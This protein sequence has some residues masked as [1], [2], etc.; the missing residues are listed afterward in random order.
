M[1]RPVVEE[2]FG[3]DG[4]QIVQV[5]G[6][7]IQRVAHGRLSVLSATSS[8]EKMLFLLCE[9]FS[10]P[11]V[12]QPVM[13][14]DDRLYLLPASGGKTYVVSLDAKTPPES[15]AELERVL[16]NCTNFRAR[17]TQNLVLDREIGSASA[18]ARAGAGAGA[19]AAAAASSS[20]STTTAL[21]PSDGAA[22]AAAAAAGAAEAPSEL[23]LLRPPAL[24]HLSVADVGN[25]LS[26]GVML[27]GKVTANA[28]VVGADF[29]GKG[30]RWA[31]G[32]AAGYMGKAEQPAHFTDETR[33]RLDQ[34]RMVSK[35]AVVV[36]SAVVLGAATMARSLG[37][38]V[39]GAFLSTEYGKSLSSNLS[40]N[41]GSQT[42]VAVRQVA[43]SS[44][45]AFGEVW[46]GLE[47]AA[48][49]FGGHAAGATTSF[50]EERYGKEAALIATKSLDVAGDVGQAALNM[51][52]VSIGGLVRK[53]G[54][55]AAKDVLHV[56]AGG[57]PGTSPLALTN[58]TPGAG[59]GAP[60]ALTN[61]G[62]G[63]G[64]GGVDAM[65]A[66]LL[67]NGMAAMASMS[68]AAA[69]SSS[70][71]GAAATPVA[72]IHAPAA[73]ATPRASTIPTPAPIVTAPPAAAAS[74]AA[75]AAAAPGQ[76]VAAQI[77]AQRGEDPSGH[78]SPFGVVLKKLGK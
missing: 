63:G 53:T 52:N 75:A 44:L 24:S 35:T 3:V 69:S 15:V 34:A 61:G 58:G 9:D 25:G 38:A 6:G 49:V 14:S 23:S 19:G 43:A 64:G 36:S 26:H 16:S 65:Q 62:G 73:A 54:V 50:V 47:T 28:L 76:S 57:Q 21:V 74:H 7:D 68:A 71:S 32:Q 20:S 2:L 11:L 10:Y 77:R 29:A 1:D 51:R 56:S 46:D 72:Q 66:M 78:T 67:M 18:G 48:K 42:G 55:E 60:L 12:D 22:A 41:S 27:A 45:V 5:A 59:S 31:A 4:A 13:K 30:V 17:Q 33:T 39:S 8:A 40:N 37:A 70:S